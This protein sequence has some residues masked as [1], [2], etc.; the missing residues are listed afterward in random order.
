ML[1]VPARRHFCIPVL[2]LAAVYCTFEHLMLCG[3]LYLI[4]GDLDSFYYLQLSCQLSDFPLSLQMSGIPIRRV[5]GRSYPV[6]APNDFSGVVQIE[7]LAEGAFG[8]V[9]RARNKETGKEVAI[10]FLPRGATVNKH[11]G[12]CNPLWPAA[13]FERCWT[14][15]GIPSSMTIH[16]CD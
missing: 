6:I 15:W 8:F 16:S 2:L 10:K 11:V 13:V 4:G 14:C 1:H 12:M 3:F 9:Q 5:L 7:D